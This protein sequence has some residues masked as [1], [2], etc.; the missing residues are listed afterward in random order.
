[1]RASRLVSVMF[2]L[3]RRRGATATELADELGV[4]V[5]TIYRDVSALQSAG[6]PIWT[7]S[8]PGGGIRLVEG[9]RTRLDGLTGDEA[10]ALFLAGA[11]SAVADLGLG[12]ILTAAESKVI[13]TLPPELRGRASR[14]RERFHLDAP[15][16][17]RDGDVPAHLATVAD[18]VWSGH[19]LDISYRRSD[20]SVQRR[21]DPLGLVLKAGV[22]YLVAAH[23]QAVRTYRV[24]RIAEAKRV[25]EPASRPPGFDLASWWAASAAEFD[26]SLLRYQCRLRLSP[27]AL[28]HLKHHVG[29]ASAEDAL[30]SAGPPDDDGWREVVLPTE[31]EDVA[32]DQLTALAPGVE[33]ID[34]PSLRVTL[35]D[36]GVALAATNAP[37]E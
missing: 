26:R 28:R 15:G 13:A 5:R 7:E 12:A 17:F 24:G 37:S 11:P 1:M 4:S 19:R 32:A 2:V 6:V 18:A 20:R 21:L 33:V 23:R 9:W 29:P 27:R 8:G 31:G 34:P 35:H 25:D 10:A 14:L 3:Q 36:V 22:W 16:W 30:A